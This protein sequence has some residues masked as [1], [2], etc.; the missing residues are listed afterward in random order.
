[1]IYIETVSTRDAN[2][3]PIKLKVVS[4]QYILQANRTRF[5]QNQ[6]DTIFTA[7]KMVHLRRKCSIFSSSS[8]HSWHMVST[9]FW[10]N[11]VLL[12]CKIYCPLT[13]F[14]FIGILFASLVDT[15]D[16]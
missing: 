5:N 1:L 12:A 11:R 4:G 14:N 9:W 8:P 7:C 2:R 15:E 3:I 13:T 6:V 10:L 16:S